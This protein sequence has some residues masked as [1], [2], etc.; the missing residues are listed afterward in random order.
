MELEY[1]TQPIPIVHQPRAW[2]SQDTVGGPVVPTSASTFVSRRRSVINY[3]PPPGPP[4]SQ[5]IPSIPALPPTHY[6]LLDRASGAL[7]YDNGTSSQIHAYSRPSGSPNLAAI[8]S[9]SQA[10]L[11][12]AS[13]SGTSP[14]P[15]ASS[16]S[17]NLSDPPP[18]SMLRANIQSKQT[19]TTTHDIA[20]DRLLLAPESRP[21]ESRPS[22]RRALTKALELA[23]EAVQLDSSN[24][25]PYAAVVAY[26][27]SVALLS[28]VMERVMRGED[29]T[30][31]H[32]K[33]NGRRRS[34]VAQEEE[35][36][37][38]KAIV[39]LSWIANLGHVSHWFFCAA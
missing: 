37:R 26:G 9:Y 30:E 25:D 12:A 32:R 28:Q 5:P 11:A 39:S 21:S 15:S 22:S 14:P 13:T 18:R 6:G 31:S 1:Q 17:D 8:A 35:V 23:R 34:V 36:R 4:P 19:V 33:Q 3:A 27:Q 20:P 24:V 2:Q 7:D 29:S 38:L 16:S 10:R